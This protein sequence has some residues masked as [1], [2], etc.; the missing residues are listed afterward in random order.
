[1]S[2]E[3][4]N[5]IICDTC[6]GACCREMGSP[7]FLPEDIEKLPR[8]VRRNYK[9]RLAI[10][11]A[12]GW[13]EGLCFWLNYGRCIFY[14]HRPDICREFEPGSKACYIWRVKY[15]DEVLPGILPGLSDDLV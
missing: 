13:P 9:R 8:Y 11:A 7:P 15:A 4:R 10:H 6:P 3:T 14:G 5:E 2:E 12:S 1:M